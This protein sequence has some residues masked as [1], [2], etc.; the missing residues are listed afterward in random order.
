M[1]PAHN[2][3]GQCGKT[4]RLTFSYLSTFIC[5]LPK[6]FFCFVTKIL[7]KVVSD[8]LDAASKN[9][10]KSAAIPA[11]GTGNFRYPPDVVAEVMFKTA[12][13]FSKANPQTSIKDV[14][15]VLFDKD[16]PT[17]N[18]SFFFQIS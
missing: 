7:G 17:C 10:Y 16:Q 1:K 5:L 4:L 11:L 2:A 8:A 15:F 18:V 12:L 3:F 9:G 14:T 6:Y 13:D